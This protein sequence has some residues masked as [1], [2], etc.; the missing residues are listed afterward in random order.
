MASSVASTPGAAPTAGGAQAPKGT[1]L[2][3][4]EQMDAVRRLV[5]IVARLFYNDGHVLVVDQL[6]S[7]AVYVGGVPAPAH[8]QDPVRCARAPPGDPGA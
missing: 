8:T 5:Q 6:V 2:A 3:T 4:P 7:V 1:T